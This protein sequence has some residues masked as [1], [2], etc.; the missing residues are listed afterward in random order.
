[1]DSWSF[2]VIL[3]RVAFEK[4]LLLDFLLFRVVVNNVVVG[5]HFASELVDMN[6][7]LLDFVVEIYYYKVLD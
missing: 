5:F 2:V 3:R 6:V 4:S 1:M 7:Y